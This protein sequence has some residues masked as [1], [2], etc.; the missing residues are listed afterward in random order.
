VRTDLVQQLRNDV[1][2]GTYRVNANQ[3]AARMLRSAAEEGAAPAD[4]AQA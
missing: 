4:G 2:D 1:Q 3:V